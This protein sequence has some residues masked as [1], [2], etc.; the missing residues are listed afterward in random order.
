LFLEFLAFFSESLLFFGGRAFFYFDSFTLLG[1]F[2]FALR[3]MIP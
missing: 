3:K 2:L 1:L